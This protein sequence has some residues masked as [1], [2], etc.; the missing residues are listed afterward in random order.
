MVIILEQCITFANFVLALL[1]L[2]FT[3]RHEY[4]LSKIRQSEKLYDIFI[5]SRLNRLSHVR[6]LLVNMLGITESARLYQSYVEDF[7][8]REKTEILE[9]FM[10]VRFELDSLIPTLADQIIIQMWLDY[11][12]TELTEELDKTLQVIS[13]RKQWILLSKIYSRTYELQ[14]DNAKNSTNVSTLVTNDA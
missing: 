6:E 7:S 4:Q 14:R 10:K 13:S 9:N 3:L 11:S 2:G 12:K 8:S 1:I 5:H